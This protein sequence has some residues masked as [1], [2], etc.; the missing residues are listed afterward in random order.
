MPMDTPMDK[1]LKM[2][3]VFDGLHGNYQIH[4]HQLFNVMINN[5]LTAILG[6]TTIPQ[7]PPKKEGDD[8]FE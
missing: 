6:P 4:T 8:K 1:F 7:P 3:S 5:K 2:G